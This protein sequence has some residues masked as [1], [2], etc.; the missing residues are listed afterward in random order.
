MF[1]IIFCHVQII[2]YHFLSCSNNRVYRV[3]RS[4]YGVGSTVQQQIAGN[5]RSSS[6]LQYHL[7]CYSTVTIFIISQASV[8]VSSLSVSNHLLQR[9]LSTENIKHTVFK[10]EKQRKK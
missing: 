4:T 7:R 6:V 9:L 8:F 2:V 1:I 3:E 10:K 5:S